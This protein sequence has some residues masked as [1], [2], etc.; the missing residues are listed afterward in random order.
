MA[1]KSRTPASKFI[2]SALATAMVTAALPVYAQYSSQ[3]QQCA[4]DPRNFTP[5]VMIAACNALIQ[6]GQWSGKYAAWL[7]NNIGKGYQLKQD[8][9]P[10]LNAYNQALSLD[11]NDAFAYC[12]RGNTKNFVTS[13]SGDQDIAQ[14]RKLDAALACDK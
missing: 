6:A 3:V 2:S 8:Y 9:A 4:N 5:D 7:Y 14:S 13:G 1:T 12:G 11:P 10:S